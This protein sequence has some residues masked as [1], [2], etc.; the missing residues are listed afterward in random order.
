MYETQV[1]K[2]IKVQSMMRAF[3]AKRNIASKLRKF[4]QDSGKTIDNINRKGTLLLMPISMNFQFKK[5]KRKD[6]QMMMQLQPFKKVRAKRT[7]LKQKNRFG[8]FLMFSLFI[9]P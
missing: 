6:N 2:I 4:R 9:H 7:K 3:L 5:N 8:Y 1:K